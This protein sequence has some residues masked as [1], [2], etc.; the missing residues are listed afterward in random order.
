[1]RVSLRRTRKPEPVP[2]M[3]LVILAFFTF[4]LAFWWGTM[5]FVASYDVN[6]QPDL[7]IVYPDY[8]MDCIPRLVNDGSRDVSVL[9]QF[10]NQMLDTNG[11]VSVSDTGFTVNAK[12]AVADLTVTLKPPLVIPGGGT[13]PVPQPTWSRAEITPSGSISCTEG[14]ANDCIINVT[15]SSIFSPWSATTGPAGVAVRAEYEKTKPGEARV[16]FQLKSAIDGGAAKDTGVAQSPPPGSVSFTN[17]AKSVAP[18]LGSATWE[19]QVLL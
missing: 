19:C 7:S 15:S 2:N 12:A 11:G 16:D 18:V 4:F 17:N 5:V 10:G 14:P 3:H 9:T 1:M 8:A 6:D 13:A